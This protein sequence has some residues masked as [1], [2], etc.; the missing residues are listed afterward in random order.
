MIGCNFPLF[1]LYPLIIVHDKGLGQPFSCVVL[2][3]GLQVFV[4]IFFAGKFYSLVWLF[5][6]QLFDKQI[7]VFIWNQDPYMPYKER[8]TVKIVMDYDR[9]H[10]RLFAKLELLEVFLHLLS[11][12]FYILSRFSLDS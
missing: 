4:D 8:I 1:P 5:K 2:V 10:P 6:G 3:F 7:A 9:K 11:M 12:D